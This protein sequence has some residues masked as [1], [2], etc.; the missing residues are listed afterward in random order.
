MSLVLPGHHLTV[1]P[2]LRIVN[3]LPCDLTYFI[4]GTP[5]RA[6]LPANKAASVFEV[7]CTGALR[8]GVHL[9]NFQRCKPINIP[10]AT[11][12]DTVLI[13]LF[14]QFGRLLQLKVCFPYPFPIA[15]S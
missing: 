12:S 7:S 14:D 8:F 2:A 10:P 15:K 11:F 13:N 9:E 3:L 4:E 1:G 6:R 5:I